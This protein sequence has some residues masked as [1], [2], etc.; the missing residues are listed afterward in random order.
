[1]RDEVDGG[2]V[3]VVARPSVGRL[4]LSVVVCVAVAGGGAAGVGGV[5]I[6]LSQG[7]RWNRLGT[8]LAAAQL[9]GVL[10]ALFNVVL[11]AMAMFISGHDLGLLILLLGYSLAIALIF[12]SLVAARLGAGLDAIR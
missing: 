11:T 9:V 4:I 12:S 7:R 5:L 8:R 2:V 6:W 1:M 3:S 10:V